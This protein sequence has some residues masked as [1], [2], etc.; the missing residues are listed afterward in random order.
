V[1]ILIA[2]VVTGLVLGNIVMS[3]HAR[4]TLD[5]DV[6]VVGQTC[7]DGAVTDLRLHISQE[8][9]PSLTVTPHVWSSRQ[10]VQ[11]TWEPSSITVYDGSQNVTISAPDERAVLNGDRG[12]V[13]IAAGQQRA[14]ENFEVRSCS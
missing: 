12:Q 14:I 4:A 7:E 6:E 13:W 9:A 5:A 1:T 11:F 8:S 2:A 10:H 3:G